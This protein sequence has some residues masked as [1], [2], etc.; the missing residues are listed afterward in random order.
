MN[1]LFLTNVIPEAQREEASY[2][3]FPQDDR[4]GY[5]ADASKDVQVPRDSTS[6]DSHWTDLK[7][8]RVKKNGYPRSRTQDHFRPRDTSEADSRTARDREESDE[9]FAREIDS[10]EADWNHI[11]LRDAMRQQLLELSHRSV[12]EHSLHPDLV[13]PPVAGRR[14]ARGQVN[15]IEQRVERKVKRNNSREMIKKL[16]CRVLRDAREA[17]A[18]P[19]AT[20]EREIRKASRL[21]SHY[22]HLTKKPAVPD[23]YK[24]RTTSHSSHQ[25]DDSFNIT[26]ASKQLTKR[27]ILARQSKLPSIQ[28]IPRAETSTFSVELIHDIKKAFFVEPPAQDRMYV[29]RLNRIAKQ[30]SKNYRAG[31][32]L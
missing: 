26:S 8:F 18:L 27:T 32:K 24:L 6:R 23:H 31:G 7:P 2:D 21:E 25:H 20:Y 11:T 4:Q 17:D 12:E 9:R 30:V 22:S 28:P 1:G 3:S 19:F 16:F 10:Y 14:P 13:K 29:S 5:A 15:S